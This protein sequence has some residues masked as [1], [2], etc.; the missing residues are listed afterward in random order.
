LQA[1]GVAP[2][3]RS[4]LLQ[5]AG[6]A[7][8]SPHFTRL[9]LQQAIAQRFAGQ[10]QPPGPLGANRDVEALTI[11]VLR[12]AVAMAD[13]DLRA[14]ME[15]MK[16]AAARKRAL[17]AAGARLPAGATTRPPGTTAERETLDSSG[18]EEL[19]QMDQLTLQRMMEKKAQL[20]SMLSNLLKAVSNDAHTVIKNLK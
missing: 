13:D 6:D 10:I 12:A 1:L 16:T 7:A 18:L 9:R 20:D 4:W 19:S 15:E 17:R 8:R 2:A 5:Q 14:L 3:V 11:Q